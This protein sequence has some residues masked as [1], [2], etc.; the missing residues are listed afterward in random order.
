[1][2]RTTKQV[3]YGSLYGC[4]WLLCAFGFYVVFLKP[5]P[6]CTDGLRNQDEVEVDC[7]GAL[8]VS[9]EIKKLAPLQLMPVQLLATGDERRTTVVVEARNPNTT[10]GAEHVVYDLVLSARN[11]DRIAYTERIDIPLYPGELKYRVAVN[12]PVSRADITS[13]TT[14]LVSVSA[15]R[16][17]E[18]FPKPRIPLRDVKT[19]VVNGRAVITGSVKNENPFVLRRVNISAFIDLPGKGTQVASKTVVNDLLVAEERGFQVILPLIDGIDTAA[20]TQPR[21]VV[22]GER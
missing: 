2:T 18:A 11:P 1:M 9:C 12:V 5:A 14:T 3:L 8:C 7:G 6:S 22:D 15:W 13:A 21:I 16:P 4:F 19:T 20:L 10:Y 17:A